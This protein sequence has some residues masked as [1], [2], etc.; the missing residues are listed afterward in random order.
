MSLRSK[1]LLAFAA[2]VVSATLARAA[3]LVIPHQGRLLDSNDQPATGTV[4]LAFKLYAKAADVGGSTEAPLWSARYEGVVLAAGGVYGL[5]LGEG[6]GNELDSAKFDGG[7]RWI[8]VTVG[9]GRELSPRLRLASTPVAN[10]ALDARLLGGRDSAYYTN[11]ANLTGTLGAAVKFEGQPLADAQI[12]SAAAW[13]AKL[14][15][16]NAQA[17]FTGGGTAASPLALAKADAANDGYLAKADFARFDGKLSEVAV[18]GALAGKG[19]SADP[20][21][22][23]LALASGTAD[24]L[25]SATDKAKLDALEGAGLQVLDDRPA[26][27]K[28]GS[29][30]FN[31]KLRATEVFANGSW[32]SY[33]GLRSCAEIKAALPSAGDGLYL[34]N[35][36][37]VQAVETFCDMTSPKGP[38]TLVASIHEDAIGTYAQNVGRCTARDRWSGTTGNDATDKWGTGAWANK[39]TFGAAKNATTDDF[40]HPAYFAL[41]ASDIMIWHVPNGRTT[42]SWSNDALLRYRTDNKFLKGQGGNLPG[43]FYRYPCSQGLGGGNG[44]SF[45]VTFDKGNTALVDA[46]ICPNCVTESDPGFVQFR[47]YNNEGACHA[48][49][50]AVRATGGNTEH[51][52]L[53]GAGHWPESASQCGDYAGWA[54]DST[55]TRAGWASDPSMRE[56]ATLIFYR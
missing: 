29:I 3:P 48:L 37:G 2:L 25:L 9:G 41:D 30:I 51:F 1:T 35:P 52:C 50:P 31:K 7:D 55:T 36:T 11:A 34:I 44:P 46:Y 5:N 28:E 8:G 15:A 24:G 19:T 32:S 18:S 17:P 16:V 13:S 40:K 4:E 33:G 38:W 21:R 47:V 23:A 39:E 6:N 45:D 49:C 10:V 56:A 22:L 26:S 27:P 42:A 14:D 12:A 53:G 20:I 54:W 43:L